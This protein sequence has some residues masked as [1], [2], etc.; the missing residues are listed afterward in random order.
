MV[1][2]DWWELHDTIPNDKMRQLSWTDDEGNISL[3]LG[4]KRGVSPK[5]ISSL[6]L[7]EIK[8]YAYLV[9]NVK[10]MAEGFEDLLVVRDLQM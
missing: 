2:T 1:S 7:Q 4:R 5:F 6:Q 8:L 10:G 3:I 9:P